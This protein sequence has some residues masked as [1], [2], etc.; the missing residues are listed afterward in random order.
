MFNN[1]CPRSHNLSVNWDE[2]QIWI[3]FL[4]SMILLL[5][6]DALHTMGKKWHS[7]SCVLS[8]LGHIGCF[9]DSGAHSSAVS[10]LTFLIL[11]FW[12]LISVS[13]QGGLSLLPNGK[14]LQSYIIL[15]IFFFTVVSFKYFIYMSPTLT[16]EDRECHFLFPFEFCSTE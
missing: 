15:F 7:C 4:R 3:S 12:V 13:P 8:A 16:S 10:S 5:G 9:L 1:C 11:Y 2:C 14:H 6:H